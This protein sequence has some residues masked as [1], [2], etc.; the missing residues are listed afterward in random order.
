MGH[1]HHRWLGSSD[2]QRPLH[3]ASTPEHGR[4][5]G[6]H[7]YYTVAGP[8]TRAPPPSEDVWAAA[9]APPAG[10]DVSASPY[11]RNPDDL[12]LPRADQTA[13]SGTSMHVHRRWLLAR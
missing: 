9:S 7:H 12:F 3:P 4:G 10:S 2:E 5:M 8:H 11:K 6:T 1:Y 13:P